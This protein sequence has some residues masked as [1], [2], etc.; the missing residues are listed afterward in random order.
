MFRLDQN[1]IRPFD[2]DICIIL[3][4]PIILEAHMAY[5]VTYILLSSLVEIF[6]FSNPQG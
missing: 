1:S 6:I 5:K 4:E 2:E 3:L